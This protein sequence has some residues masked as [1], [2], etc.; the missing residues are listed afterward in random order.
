[1]TELDELDL[2]G[3]KI[4][5]AGL[6]RI[7]RL[8][9]LKSLDLSDTAITDAGLARLKSLGR[10]SFLSVDETDATPGG[11]EALRESLMPGAVIV[12]GG[13][14]ARAGRGDATR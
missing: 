2:R 9:G 10:L 8:K 1:M 3:S 13:K 12:S 11:V 14:R 5:D 7:A 6:E 4:T